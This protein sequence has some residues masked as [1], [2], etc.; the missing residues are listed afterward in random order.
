MLFT[1]S[2]VSVDVNIQKIL[3]SVRINEWLDE[4]LFHFKW[5]ILLGLLTFF[6]LVWWKLLDKKRLPEIM[7]YA[8]LTLI[9][10][11]GIVEYG[12]ELTLWDYP[13]DISPIFP[14]L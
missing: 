10:A 11:M 5:W 3:T 6:I 9:L 1:V 13:N 12:G 7:L 8:V 2:G 4:D 14:V